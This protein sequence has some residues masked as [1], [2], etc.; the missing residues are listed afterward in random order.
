MNRFMKYMSIF[1]VVLLSYRVS[2][3]VELHD[4]NPQLGINLAG[5]VDWS[6]EL[7]F[8]DVFRLS[9]DWISQKEGADWGGGPELELDEHGWVKRL[10]PNA[11]AE[12][13]MCTIDGGH[14]PSGEYTILYDGEGTLNVWN[15]GEF[16]SE[17]PGRIVMRVDSSK[18]AI[19]LQIRETNPDNYIRNIRVIM[20]GY[21]DVY[22]QQP[23]YPPFLDLWRGMACLRYMDFMH[24]NNSIISNW[25]ERPKPE[26]ANTTSKGMPLEWMIDLA[27]E[28]D[29]DPWF[30]IPHLADDEYVR[31]FAKMVHERLNPELCVYVEY[32]NEVWNGQF[33]QNQYA[34]EQGIELGFATQPWEAAWFYTAYRSVQI[35]TIF[36][37]VFGGKDRL[38]RVLPTQAA[39]SYVSYQILEFQNAYEHA[40]ALAVAP[41]ISFNVS[42]SG[43][44]NTS[45]VLSWTL[46]ETMDYMEQT[47]LPQSIGWMEE[48][49]A[50]ADEFGLKLIAYEGG[51]HMVGIYG[52]ENNDELTARLHAANR[53]PRMGEI[54]DAY[55][56]AWVDNGGDLFTHFSSIGTWSKW[57]SWGL[58]EHMDDDKEQSPK[59]QS[60]INWGR[61]LGQ[62]IGEPNTKVGC[63]LYY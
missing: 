16:I 58:L 63:F 24:T 27:N 1:I 42:G 8:V 61:S 35:F 36:E 25:D 23:W 43:D 15:A 10:E 38:V 59:Y 53:H 44:L 34:G 3:S 29:A 37:D 30:C 32:S 40:D 17:V 18:E 48:Q 14:Y 5:P 60:T 45:T 57:G 41:Y 6:T 11:W 13:L 31:Q 62:P 9:R 50:A 28:L 39:N 21:E 7:L 49:K 54:Y 22:E 12:T 47:A 52:E 46:D 20:P 19:F 26:D 55:Y 33:A 51:Q 4:S 56:H 2:F